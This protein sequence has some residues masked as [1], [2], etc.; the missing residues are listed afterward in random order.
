M[1]RFTSTTRNTSRNRR[2]IGD[3]TAADRPSRRAGIDGGAV[4][5][6]SPPSSRFGWQP[7]ASAGVLIWLPAPTRLPRPTPEHARLR[8]TDYGPN[9][10]GHR[11]G[12]EVECGQGECRG[13]RFRRQRARPQRRVVPAGNHHPDAVLLRGG[14]T[15]ADI[16]RP[17]ADADRRG[18]PAAAGRGAVPDPVGVRG[19]AAGGGRG[20]Q[21][22]ADQRFHSP[23]S[24][25]LHWAA[26]G[27]RGGGRAVAVLGAVDSRGP[28]GR[29]AATVGVR[30][31]AARRPRRGGALAVGLRGAA[32]GGDR[33][34]PPFPGDADRPRPRQPLSIPRTRRYA[35]MLSPRAYR[36]VRGML[37]GCRGRGRSA[38]PGNGGPPRSPPS[39]A[40]RRP[41][42]SAPP[43]RGR[44]AAG[45]RTPTVAAGRPRGPRLSTAP[46][47]ASART[48]PRP[49][50]AAQRRPT[51]AGE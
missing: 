12:R 10:R 3:R 38:S 42:A 24:V 9:E 21:P 26:E 19:P 35:P 34:G 47:T 27:G 30:R 22:A 20:S 44:R 32:E 2:R 5:A 46:R 45:L 16:R 36:R 48:H 8:A 39:A 18:Q 13:Q 11:R 7:T 15:A 14:S 40:P 49:P 41:T 17:T 4:I 50:S 28:R 29:P 23:A 33:G 31:P 6:C 25:G 43:R 1:A 51:E 37:R